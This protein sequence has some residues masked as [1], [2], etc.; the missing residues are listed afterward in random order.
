MLLVFQCKI[1]QTIDATSKALQAKD[2]DLS[3]ASRRLQNCLKELEKYR[4]EFDDLKSEANVSK[5]WSVPSEFANTRQRKI[6]RHFDELCEDERLRDPEKFFKVNVFYCV[7]DII[8]NQ[9][10]S[11]F[12]GMNEIVSNFIVL[13]PVTLQTLNDIDL[14]KKASE[15]IELYKKDISASFSKELLSFRSTF[16][17]EIERSF[18]IR[19]LADLLI[20]K[21]HFMCSSFP[22]VCTALI[23]FLTIPIT[24]ASA[25][26]S[27]SKLKLI[28]T[29]LRN[30]IGQERLR[31]LAVLSIENDIAQKLNLDIIIDVFAEQKARKKI[32]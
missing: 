7:L 14:S 20:I 27:F 23:L 15:F 3:N 6:K 22:E 11:R 2:I 29:Y 31:N 4:N 30:S 18:S 21:N 13:Q 5:K 28:K 16:R 24:T 25:E 9:L 26:R 1:L 10:R 19:E 32:F 12:S 8:I 17:Q